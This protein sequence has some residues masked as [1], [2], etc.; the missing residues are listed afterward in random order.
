[1]HWTLILRASDPKRWKLINSVWSRHCEE[2]STGVFA[3]AI[4]FCNR[5]YVVQSP[6]NA[7]SGLCSFWST[8]AYLL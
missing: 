6:D 4:S 3:E 7:L 8:V 1:M 2:S 5:P